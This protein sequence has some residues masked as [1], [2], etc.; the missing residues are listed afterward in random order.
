MKIAVIGATGLVGGVTVKELAERGHEVIAIARNT[1]KVENQPNVTVVAADVNDANFAEQLKGVDAVI[2]T[3]NAG[4]G[5]PNFVADFKKG[6]ANIIEAAKTAEVPYLLVV[7][8][9][10]SLFVAPELQLVDTPEFPKEIYEGAN[11]ARVLLDDLK[12]RRDV[13]WSFFSPAAMFA[14]NPVK[15]EKSGKYRLGKDN[16]LMNENGIP[17]DISAPDLACVLADDVEKKAHLFE[18][19]TAAEVE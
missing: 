15:F 11:A 14:V 13:N 12:P 10:G 18:R 16:V 19:F 1:E 7:G 4:W 6:Y 8:G 3:Y 2:S 17:A 5:N 9:A